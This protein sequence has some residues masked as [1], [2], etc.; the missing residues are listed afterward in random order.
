LHNIHLTISVH[1]WHPQIFMGNPED[2]YVNRW[3][4]FAHEN[5]ISFVNLFPLFINGENPVVVRDKYYIEGDNHW[6]EYGHKKVAKYLSG[7]FLE[8]LKTSSHE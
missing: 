2:Y 6:N 7:Y 8:N 4:E 5:D 1:P 3:A